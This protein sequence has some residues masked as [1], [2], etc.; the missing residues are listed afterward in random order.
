MS[1][2]S[3]HKV[4]QALAEGL[5]YSSILLAIEQYGLS[6]Y[7][8]SRINRWVTAE[9]NWRSVEHILVEW[10]C[11]DGDR[12]CLDKLPNPVLVRPCGTLASLYNAGGKPEPDAVWDEIDTSP[13]SFHKT[14]YTYRMVYDLLFSMKLIS[15]PDTEAVDDFLANTAL[16][17]LDDEFHRI[18]GVGA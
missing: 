6:K 16:F 13:D 1:D 3:Q 9:G 10:D 5:M 2:Q 4:T 12:V 14:V 18:Q 11:F 15:M 7:L 17:Q 8:G